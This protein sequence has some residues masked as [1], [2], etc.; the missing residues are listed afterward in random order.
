[1]FY[2]R[3]IIPA[4]AQ[5]STKLPLRWQMA[6]SYFL[7]NLKLLQVCLCY[8]LVRARFSRREIVFIVCEKLIE[9][10]IKIE[11]FDNMNEKRSHIVIFRSCMHIFEGLICLSEKNVRVCNSRSAAVIF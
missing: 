1:M 10:D 6:P 7:R 9:S 5:S 11:V 2:R 4:G 8:L 3:C